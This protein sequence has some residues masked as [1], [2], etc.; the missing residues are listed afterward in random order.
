M[1]ELP[2]SGGLDL[3]PGTDAPTPPALQPAAVYTLN[4]EE[5]DKPNSR[6]CGALAWRLWDALQV[7]IVLRRSRIG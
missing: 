2:S 7:R 5:P 3:Y 1:S 4:W 6:R